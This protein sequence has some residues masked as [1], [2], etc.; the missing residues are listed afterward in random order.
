[1]RAGRPFWH[2][3]PAKNVHS[4]PKSTP[5]ASVVQCAPAEQRTVDRI[6][7]S[8]ASMGLAALVKLRNG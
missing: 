6:C 2:E 4:A 8:I 5:T 7:R 3:C 1:M